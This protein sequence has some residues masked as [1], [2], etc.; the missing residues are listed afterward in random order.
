[1][2]SLRDRINA[3]EFDNKVS[4]PVSNKEDRRK[5][6]DAYRRGSAEAF[7]RFK[8]AVEEDFVTAGHPKADLLWELAWSRGHSGGLLE[9][10]SEYEEL[11]EL[12]W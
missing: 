4:Y 5:E 2:N 11:V 7:K 9:V 6:L 8:E 1:M 3:G 12:I 10:V